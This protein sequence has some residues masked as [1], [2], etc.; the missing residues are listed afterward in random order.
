M[1]LAFYYIWYRPERWSSATFTPVEFYNSTDPRTLR[2]HCEEAKRAGIDGFI[3]SFWGKHEISKLDSVFKIFDECDIKYTVYFESSVS[4]AD[5]IKQIDSILRVFGKRKNFLRFHG[6]PVIFIYGR[7]I[8]SLNFLQMDSVI[9]AFPRLIIFADGGGQ[10]LNVLFRNLHRYI[11]LDAD[12]AFY[13]NF[14][15]GVLGYCAVP[16]F[17]GFKYKEREEPLVLHQ[18]GMFY[19]S[20]IKMAS[21]SNA[22]ILLITSFNEWWEGTNIEPSREFGDLFLRITAKYA[23]IFKKTRKKKKIGNLNLQKIDA[24][25]CYIQ[26]PTDFTPLLF[27]KFRILK[28]PQKI[29]NCDLV[30]Y[31]GGERYDTAWNPYLLDYLNWGKMLVSGG[32]FPFY[33][34]KDGNYVNMAHRF[35][36]K[37]RVVDDNTLRGRFFA[38]LIGW[39]DTIMFYPWGEHR[40]RDILKWD[41]VFYKLRVCKDKCEDFVIGGRVG[42]VFYVWR[43]L[44]E[45]KYGIEAVSK[46][47]RKMGF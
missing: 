12:E 16:V 43:G 47:L 11:F 37:M 17:P 22:D 39:E 13:E 35:G 6:D 20:L 33:Y 5:L 23:K 19:E 28:E 38:Y 8:N 14:C 21:K 4:A 2:R 18:N 29:E 3:V 10:T 27:R 40:I 36:L 24:T 42:N 45:S 32:P 7:I 30:V 26:E 31:G 46:V 34:D 25:A 9:R 41:E 44:V 1:I 15:K